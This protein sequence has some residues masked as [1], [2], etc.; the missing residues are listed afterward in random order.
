MSYPKYYDGLDEDG[1]VISQ[2]WRLP[3]ERG[4][5]EHIGD[6]KPLQIGNVLV[7]I[8]KRASIGS[9]LEKD[10]DSPIEQQLGAAIILNFEENGKPL[11]LCVDLEAEQF[12]KGL[13]L[14]PQFKW[15][16]YRSDW[17]IYNPKTTGA[18]L[19]ECDGA[20]FHSTEEQQEHD[21]KKDAAAHDRGYLTMRFTGSEIHKQADIC[22]QRIF[23]VVYGGRGGKK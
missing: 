22:A 23:D 5:E 10:T 11:K 13:L 14:I 15:S 6:F 21:K 2:P 8:L 7:G 4:S 9:G 20:A 19:I 3:Y 12:P 18:L 16:Y 1:N 17:A